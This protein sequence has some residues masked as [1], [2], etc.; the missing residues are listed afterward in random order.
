MKKALLLPFLTLVIGVTSVFGQS[1]IGYV[2]YDYV[3]ALMPEISTIQTKLEEKGKTY[4]SLINEKKTEMSQIEQLVEN[5]PNLD[6]TIKEAKVRRYQNLQQEIQEFAYSAQEKLEIAEVELMKPVY[7]KLNTTIADVAK[8]KGFDYI[9]SDNNPGGFIVVY[10]KNE[11]DNITKAVM[12]KLAIKEP[13]TTKTTT[14]QA[15]ESLMVKPK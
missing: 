2:Q 11:T 4:E 1:K 9:L 5:T 3:L 15:T 6:E 7:D 14:P 10:A 12:E 8:V 13:T